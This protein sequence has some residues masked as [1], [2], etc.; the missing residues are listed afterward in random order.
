MMN[1][2]KF[3]RKFE[4][5]KGDK[6]VF[7]MRKMMLSKEDGEGVKQQAQATIKAEHAD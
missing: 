7:Y 6:D 2:S 3:R 1:P 4:A 5:A